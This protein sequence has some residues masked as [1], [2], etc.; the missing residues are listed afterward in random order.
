MRDSLIAWSGG[1]ESTALVVWALNKGYNPLIFHVNNSWHLDSIETERKGVLEMKK[2]LGCEVLDL[3]NKSHGQFRFM[4]E[5]PKTMLNFYWWMYW[6]VFLS[7]TNPGLH[8][9]WY[10]DNNGV[11]K[12]GDG[13]GAPQSQQFEDVKQGSIRVARGLQN[14]FDVQ[15]PLRRP[16]VEL[17]NSIP[18]ELKP[19][20]HSS[21]DH[22]AW[23]KFYDR[24]KSKTNSI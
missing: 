24:E 13:L 1:V 23:V 6:G 20:V 16:K 9:C 3:E 17:W 19:H 12:E 22:E 21:D 14:S 5:K 8:V 10:G 11:F 7:C 4:S 2:I 15:C 18:D